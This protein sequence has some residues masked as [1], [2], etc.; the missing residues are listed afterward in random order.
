MLESLP[1]FYNPNKVIP[2]SVAR[3][4]HTYPPCSTH[5]VLPL[6]S[7]GLEATSSKLGLPS[8]ISDINVKV[9]PPRGFL[10]SQMV[11]LQFSSSLPFLLSIHISFN[12]GCCVGS[13]LGTRKTRLGGE[14]VCPCDTHWTK[15]RGSGNLGEHRGKMLVK[16]RKPSYES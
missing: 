8:W 5:L 12:V 14:E 7:R 10:P 3:G 13:L 16:G 15:V 11:F 2:I 1:I 4:L 6:G 9:K